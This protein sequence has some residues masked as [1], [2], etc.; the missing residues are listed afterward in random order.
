M[1]EFSDLTRWAPLKI[2]K[3]T[4]VFTRTDPELH[5]IKGASCF[6]AESEF[7]CPPAILQG[8]VID[9]EKRK[10]WDDDAD[11]LKVL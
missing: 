1:I 11:Q 8:Y 4:R 7:D 5:G 2:I 6:K 3:D 9:F 10:L